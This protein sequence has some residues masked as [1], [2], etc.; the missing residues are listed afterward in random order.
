MISPLLE[1]LKSNEFEVA[2]GFLH[3]PASV[4]KALLN[5]LDIRR[6]ALAFRCGEVTDEMIREFVSSIVGG[7]S[8]GRR[9]P[10][11]LALAALAVVLEIRPTKFAEE[12]LHDLSRLRLA[13]MKISTHV[14]CEC[15][16]NRYLVPKHESRSFGFPRR[17]QGTPRLLRVSQRLW[18]DGTRPRTG[19]RYSARVGTG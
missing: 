11:D 15:L 6:L 16:R 5:S 17:V 19:T 10:N 18:V 12:Y 4:R 2:I 7:F 14:A 8:K 13:E 9:L 3:T 1:R